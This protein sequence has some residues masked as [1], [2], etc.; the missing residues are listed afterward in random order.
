MKCTNRKVSAADSEAFSVQCSLVKVWN[1]G[2]GL[3]PAL[4]VRFGVWSRTREY[5]VGRSLGSR[6]TV[7]SLGFAIKA[8]DGRL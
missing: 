4:V 1:V 6:F 3:A 5:L 8:S 2:A 7:H